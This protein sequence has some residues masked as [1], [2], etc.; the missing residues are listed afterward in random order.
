[1]GTRTRKHNDSLK[2]NR[3]GF[4]AGKKSKARKQVIHMQ[5]TKVLPQVVQAETPESKKSSESSL[6]EKRKGLGTANQGMRLKLNSKNSIDL[7]A[8]DRQI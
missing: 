4:E 6:D 8:S 1:M 7:N 5:S 2:Q 3:I